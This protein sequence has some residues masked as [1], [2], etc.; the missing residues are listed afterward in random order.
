LLIYFLSS[1]NDF[2]IRR[3]TYFIKKRPYW[4]NAVGS[5]GWGKGP[6]FRLHRNASIDLW[7]VDFENG[8]PARFTINGDVPLIALHNPLGH[9]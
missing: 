7:K 1:Q 4:G 3:I 6:D 8:A 2:Q 5:A 9:R